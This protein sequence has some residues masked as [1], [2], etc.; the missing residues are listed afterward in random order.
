MSNST[1]I[2]QLFS[3][4]L[5]ADTQ[6]P[7]KQQAILQAAFDL[8]AEQG[9]DHTTTKDIAQRAGVAEGTVY[10]RYKTKD[11]LLA[12]V[13]APMAASVV[14]NAAT[15]FVETRIN[16]DYTDLHAYLTAIVDDRLD[17]AVANYKYL[18]IVAERALADNVFKQRMVATVGPHIIQPV[19]STLTAL[20]AKGLLIDWPVDA[21]AQFMISTMFG[22]A[23]R[24]ILLPQPVDLEAQKRMMVSFLERGLAPEKS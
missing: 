19:L 6:L 1:N 20:Q 21:I 23:Y 11:E 8:F 7:A 16:T 2:D 3:E 14:P 5:A 4:A 9:F 13:L 10:K 18:K 15:E 22:L 17:Y 24:L 12:A